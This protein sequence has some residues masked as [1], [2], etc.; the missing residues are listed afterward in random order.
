[1]RNLKKPVVR[2]HGGKWR[3][4]PWI[5]QHLPPHKTYVEPYAGAASVLL[6]KQPSTVEVYNDSN[7][8]MHNLFTVLRDQDM[9][10]RLA[11]F[12]RHTPYSIQEFY[13]A[14]ECASIDPVERARKTIVRGCQSHG[15]TGCSGG[16][17]TGWRRGIRP[18]GPSSADE[19]KQFHKQV[20]WWSERMRGVFLECGHAMDCITKWDSPDTLF[21][22]DPPYLP[23]TRIY[24]KKGYRYEMTK[25]EHESLLFQLS[26]LRGKVV[27]SGYPS[28]LY[29][30]MLFTWKRIDRQVLTTGQGCRTEVLWIKE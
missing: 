2:Y 6:R 27:L 14:Y 24:S 16:K 12:L 26:A 17:R 20:E 30:S 8:E 5:I 15:S 28:E 11:D 9:S 3:I 22:V 29:E 18:R 19:W 7:S 4:A 23:E 25:E 10:Q 1:M 13:E 21:Y